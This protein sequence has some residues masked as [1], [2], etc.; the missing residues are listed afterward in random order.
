MR[1]CEFLCIENRRKERTRKEM[2]WCLPE[3]KMVVVVCLMI[4][5]VDRR[6]SCGGDGGG[7]W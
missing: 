3:K 5:A 6:W 7:C 2:R 4:W 1:N